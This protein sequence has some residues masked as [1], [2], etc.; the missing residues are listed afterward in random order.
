[1]FR[2]ISFILVLYAISQM[3]SDPFE[4]FQNAITATFKTVEVA[5]VVSKDQILEQSD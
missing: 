3:M 1:M 5:A 2:A 4:A